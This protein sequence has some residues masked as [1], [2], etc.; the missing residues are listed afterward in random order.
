MKKLQNHSYIET[1][2]QRGV[3]Y[4]QVGQIDTAIAHFRE[5]LKNDPEHFVALK[6]LGVMY[7]R[8]KCF[9]EAEQFLEESLTMNRSDP[10]TWNYLAEVHREWGCLEKAER[11]CRQA[12]KLRSD[13]AIAHCHLGLILHKRGK[14][15]QAEQYFLTAIK[16]EPGY[17]SAYVKLFEMLIEKDRYEV[18]KQIC[19]QALKEKS[20]RN[21]H[22]RLQYAFLLLLKGD[23]AEG[24]K[25]YESRLETEGHEYT[26]EMFYQLNRPRWLG[27]SLQKKRLVILP[28]QGI[29]EEILFSQYLSEIIQRGAQVTLV[30]TPRLIPIFRRSFLHIKI[31]GWSKKNLRELRDYSF[32]FQCAIASLPYLL[33]LYDHL[34]SSR[35]GYLKYEENR[36]RTLRERYHRK[37]Q[38][39]IGISWFGGSSAI[40][41]EKRSLPLP[42]WAPILSLNH[43]FISLQHGESIKD[44]EKL[45]EQSGDLEIT[46]DK[47]I[48]PLKDMDLFASQVAACDLIISIDNATA[49]LAG[50]IG[51]R[52]WVLLPFIP[53]WRWMLKREDSPW[54]ASMQLFRQQT[55]GNWK[56][57]IHEVKESI[58]HVC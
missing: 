11:Y 55:P 22:I 15:D 53:N 50:A 6:L 42:L 34:H 4:Q 2:L 10:N 48:D 1:I 39:I 13:H 12:L 3:Q 20:P 56:E 57:V 5:V 31:I 41:Q 19:Q 25:Q 37:Q 43:H 18:A 30:C 45:K 49:H 52:V 14:T 8:K 38:L 29:G 44:I 58:T 7:L 46:H 16:L 24:W 36:A 23:W 40:E 26:R 35:F 51:K 33:R 9:V 28:E 47:T 17:I 21:I 32:D 27:E 54:F